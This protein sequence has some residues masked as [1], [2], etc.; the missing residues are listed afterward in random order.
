MT[1]ALYVERATLRRKNEKLG[2]MTTRKSYELFR[3]GEA[4]YLIEIWGFEPGKGYARCLRSKFDLQQEIN[5]KVAREKLQY[6]ETDEYQLEF[7]GGRFE[8]YDDDSFAEYV[9][10]RSDKDPSQ[11]VRDFATMRTAEIQSGRFVGATS[12]T[13]TIPNPQFRDLW[14]LGR[15]SGRKGASATQ[16]ITPL[17]APDLEIEE[18]PLVQAAYKQWG[19]FA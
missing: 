15:A 17:T 9:F 13:P 4:G 2:R 18:V 12:G 19:E 16:E 14:K 1:F 5:R 10:A 7:D 6:F 11:A 8:T 3:L